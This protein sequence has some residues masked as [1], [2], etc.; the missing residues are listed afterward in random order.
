MA[1]SIENLVQ[2]LLEKEQLMERLARLLEDERQHIVAMDTSAMETDRL[3][4]VEVIGLLEQSSTSCRRALRSAA[5]DLA[6]PGDATL[7][8]IIKVV[9]SPQRLVL[10][11]LRGRMHDLN[12]VLTRGNSFNRELLYDALGMINRSLN[13]FN[14][15]FGKES[16][17]GYGG[18]MAAGIPG[19]RLVSGAI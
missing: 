4:K 13:F 15:C 7:S 11:K 9:P 2:I 3:R 5:A 17:Y 18:Q 16:T 19:G 10:T 12:E 14:T 8:A 1:T 6:L